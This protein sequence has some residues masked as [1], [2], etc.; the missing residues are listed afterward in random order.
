MKSIFRISVLLSMVLLQTT[1]CGSENNPG[2]DSPSMD[3]KLKVVTSFTIIEDLA[4]EI[5]GDDVEIHN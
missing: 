4:R 3:G 2:A 1:G 5:G